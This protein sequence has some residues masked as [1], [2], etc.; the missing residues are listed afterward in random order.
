MN[1]VGKKKQI[2]YRHH[3][4]ALG[5]LDDDLHYGPFAPLWWDISTEKV[6]PLR[7]NMRMQT[8]INVKVQDGQNIELFITRKPDS[9]HPSYIATC[10]GM[11]GIQVSSEFEQTPSKAVN[12]AFERYCQQSGNT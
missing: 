9:V 3:L 1:K 2:R 4:I 12:G 5:E 6:T 8:P 7:V 10:N 11:T